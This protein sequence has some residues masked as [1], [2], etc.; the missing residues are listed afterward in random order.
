MEVR[1]WL[2]KWRVSLQNGA[3]AGPKAMGGVCAETQ[4]NRLG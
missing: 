3:G 4:G 1:R 2:W